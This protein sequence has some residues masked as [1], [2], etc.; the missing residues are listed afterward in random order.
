[1]TLINCKAAFY[2]TMLEVAATHPLDVIKTRLQMAK[3]VKPNKLYKGLGSRLIG[4]YP[5]RIIYWN[6]T[7][8]C[9]EKKIN[10][11]LGGAMVGFLQTTIDY[12]IEVIK[13]NK[14][15]NNQSWKNSFKK[16]NNFNAFLI[17]YKRNLLFASSVITSVSMFKDNNYASGLGG[18]IGSIISHPLDSLKTWYQSGKQ[19][20]PSHWKISDYF[21]G[22]VFRGGISFIG[23]NIGWLSYKYF[24]DLK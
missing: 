4:S 9:K 8:Y 17:H 6:S 3:N 15:I 11:M 7:S 14:V 21:R 18:L 22:V 2:A 1:M 12:P 16:V 5:M 20:Y 10:P 24:D 23:M 19:T 13:T